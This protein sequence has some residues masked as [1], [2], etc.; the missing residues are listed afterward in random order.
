M[1][2][3]FFILFISFFSLQSFGCEL[4]L[5]KHILKLKETLSPSD[6]APS[7][8]PTHITQ[9]I[10]DKISK[11]EGRVLTQTLHK[12]E[13]TIQPRAIQ[14]T[15]LDTLVSQKVP[16]SE[17]LKFFNLK[18]LTSQ[19]FLDIEDVNFQIECGHCNSLGRKQIRLVTHSDEKNNAITF[20]AEVKGLATYLVALKDI[21]ANDNNLK[22]SDFVVMTDYVDGNAKFFPVTERIEFQRTS[23]PIKRGQKIESNM[24]LGLDLVKYGNKV[25]VLFQNEAIEIKSSAIARKAGKYGEHIE[26][27]N[28]TS[29]KKI[30]AKIVDFNKAIVDL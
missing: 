2:K 9:S 15:D 14:I 26:L 4:I 23:R 20:S 3:L 12:G 27:I 28:P 30:T 8:C 7:D 19:S 13:L 29:Q 21:P 11:M 1:I 22:F 17:G 25:S 16:L 18:T 24:L 5:P 6:L 10:L